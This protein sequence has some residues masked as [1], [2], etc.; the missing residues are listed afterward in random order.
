MSGPHRSSG[1]CDVGIV[2]AAGAVRGRTPLL[3]PCRS[4]ATK[5]RDAHATRVKSLTQLLSH[6]APP[7]AELDCSQRADRGVMRDHC[8]RVFTARPLYVSSPT[9]VPTPSAKRPFTG[10]AMVDGS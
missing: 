8:T 7:S 4:W 2:P 10:A 6:V 5:Q 1:Q 3:R 9:N